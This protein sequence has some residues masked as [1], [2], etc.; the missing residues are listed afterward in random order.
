MI[1]RGQYYTVV[2]I[3]TM[4]IDRRQKLDELEG[5]AAD[6]LRDMGASDDREK[7]IMD[8]KDCVGEATYNSGDDPEAAAKA[9]LDMLGLEVEGA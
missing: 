4:Q 9:L 3:V 7:S 5:I 1:S 8:V 6:V 2:G